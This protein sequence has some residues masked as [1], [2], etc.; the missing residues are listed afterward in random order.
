MLSESV[1][2]GSRTGDA[3]KEDAICDHFIFLRV[4]IIMPK[5]RSKHG[6]SRGDFD[7]GIW[8]ERRISPPL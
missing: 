4:Q 7:F 3:G 6:L 5:K 8:E 1:G 2:K